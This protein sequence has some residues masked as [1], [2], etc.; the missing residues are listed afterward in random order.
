MLAHDG[1]GAVGGDL[2]KLVEVAAGGLVSPGWQRMA[3]EFVFDSCR[4]E[5]TQRLCEDVG[6]CF[7]RSCFRP[8]FAI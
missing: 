4:V 5:V 8:G 6:S 2:R 1:N 7:C 3:A